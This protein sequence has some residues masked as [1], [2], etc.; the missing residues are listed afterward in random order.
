M[1]AEDRAL[2][3]KVEAGFETVGELYDACK[4]RAAL[5]ECLALACEANGY[6]FGKLSA[7]TFGKLSAGMDHKA[8]LCRIKEAEAAAATRR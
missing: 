1:D 5:G 4:F 2:L 6:T 3:K 7:G 8:P